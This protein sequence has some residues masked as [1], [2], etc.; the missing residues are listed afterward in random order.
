MPPDGS[1]PPDPAAGIKAVGCV[2]FGLA[3]IG[4]AALTVFAVV[5]AGLSR[6]DENRRFTLF[7]VFAWIYVLVSMGCFGSRLSARV[8][9]TVAFYLHALGAVMMAPSVLA[10]RDGMLNL[11]PFYI[12]PV[13]WVVL[14]VRAR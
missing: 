12:L 11:W 13:L 14:I 10:S 4:V 3:T 2:L 9:F 8:L 6:G 1:S 7:L 5:F